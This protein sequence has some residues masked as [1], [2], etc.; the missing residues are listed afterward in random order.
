MPIIVSILIV[1][2][3]SITTSCNKK[4]DVA[5]PEIVPAERTIAFPDWISTEYVMGHFDPAAHSDFKVIDR[6]YADREGLFLRKDTYR[7]FQEMF[8]AAQ[9]AGHTLVIKSATRNFEYQK[10]IWERKWN[11]NTLLE[12]GVDGSTIENHVDRAKK[13]LLYSS[14][15]GTSRH[16][17]GTDIDL[18]SFNNDYFKKGKG[19]ALYKWMRD[20]AGNFGFCQPYSSKEDGRTGFE[21]ECWHWSYMP[22]SQPLTEYSKEYLKNEMIDG[23]LGSETAV[24]VNMVANY[25]LG[26]NPQCLK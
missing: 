19:V 2:L 18:N 7:S 23:F 22:I 13:I 10:G 16:H 4:G 20:N 5:T 24:T 11:G 9:Q 14:M 1:S 21:E 17:W 3:C 8:A 26:I 15:P 25:I 12:G 6:K